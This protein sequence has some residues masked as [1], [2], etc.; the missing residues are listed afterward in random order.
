MF[1]YALRWSFCVELD[2]LWTVSH[3]PQRVK[4][5]NTNDAKHQQK[6]KK[7]HVQAQSKRSNT[8]K[9]AQRGNGRKTRQAAKDGSRILARSSCSAGRVRSK[10]KWNGIRPCRHGKNNCHPPLQLFLIRHWIRLLRTR[11][12]NCFRQTT[13]KQDNPSSRQSKTTGDL[14]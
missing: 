5:P 12:I 2:A 3:R 9:R 6:K 11:L 1:F 4:K 13:C 14:R 10:N 7:R 8:N